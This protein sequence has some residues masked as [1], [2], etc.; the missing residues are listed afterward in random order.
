MKA[1]KKMAKD[2]K[3]SSGKRE[4]AEIKGMKAKESKLVKDLKE[5][6]KE[7]KPGIN[8]KVNN[9]K[10]DK[11]ISK[12]NDKAKANFDDFIY[13]YSLKN[14]IEFGKTDAGKIM[15][16]LF[17][18]GLEREKIKEVMPQMQKIIAEIN[19]MKEDERKRVFEQ[20]YKEFVKERVE[21]ERVLP[22]LPNAKEG[23]VVVRLAPYPSGALHIG[24]AKTY[25]L[26]ALYAEKYKGKILLVMDDTIGSEEKQLA[27][28][29]YTLIPEGFDW[30]GV[31]Y[32]KKIVY[33]SDRLE[34]YYGYAEK[35][36]EKGLAYVCQCAQLDMRQNRAQG[37]ECSCRE[38]PLKIQKARWKEMFK[39]LPGEAALRIKTNMLDPNPAFRDRVL[40]K[41]SDRE[42]VR[43]GKKYRVWP[44]LEMS[45]AIDDHELGITHILRGN[46]LMIESDVERFIWKAFGWKGPEITHTGLV[47]LEGVG[48]KLSKSKA[49][50][51]VN[52]GTFTGWDDPRTWSLQSLK[53]RGFLPES[54]REFVEEIGLNKSDIV[55]PIGALYA[56]N[57]K[58]VDALSE[59]FS[60]VQAPV[61]LKFAEKINV[62]SVEVP[63]HPEREE[64]RRVEVGNEIY[65]SKKDF[66]SL[67]GQEVRLL[68]LF[69]VIWDKQGNAKISSNE[70][71]AI[72]KIQWVS[73]NAPAVVLMPDGEKINGIVENSAVR[74]D[75]SATMQF[76]RF[77]FVTYQG[78]NDGLNEFWFAHD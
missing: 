30:L 33:K 39:M 69:N 24:N 11:G 59:R 43:V 60:F 29:A 55:V 18:H 28:E 74:A 7:S 38:M 67:A 32:D 19:S 77:G 52:D 54:I 35:M 44:T 63:K 23:K 50:K 64:K 56:I 36:I 13:A 17:Q 26:N 48:A 75:K 58:K 45:W 66:E 76:E 57:R 70:N 6:D 51:E 4:K 72:P 14:A 37:K 12:D 27:K 1:D 22:E 31:D 34:L 46:D 2:A 40:F 62:K 71:K 49:Q 73:H 15:P 3:K 9:N 61:K 21:V 42:H 5:I 65:I 41:I 68:H 25:V 20:K 10:V 16:K 8:K 47:R 78:I 53:R